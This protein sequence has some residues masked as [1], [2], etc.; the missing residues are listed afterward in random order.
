MTE[1]QLERMVDNM[2]NEMIICPICGRKKSVLTRDG[3]LRE[4]IHCKCKI[5]K[6]HTK[7]QLEM[8]GDY[9]YT[10]IDGKVIVL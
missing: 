7:F 3:D 2:E 1:G 5:G 4:V 8:G 10:D 9:I 6:H